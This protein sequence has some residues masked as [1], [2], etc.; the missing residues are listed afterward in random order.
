MENTIHMNIERRNSKRKFDNMF[1]YIRIYWPLIVSLLLAVSGWTTV[2]NTI[3]ILEVKMESTSN[4]SD[5]S[6]HRITILEEQN[7][8]IFEGIRRIENK[9]DRR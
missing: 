1:D 5:Q 9:L 2:R 3:A 8:Q 6:E 4:K 7:K